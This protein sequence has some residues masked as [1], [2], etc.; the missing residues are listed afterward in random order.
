M[1][2]TVK[3]IGGS[4]AVVIPKEI[5]R[6]MHL[7]E[8]STLEISA[9]GNA[10]IL[11]KPRARARQS[12][13]SI[14]QNIRPASYKRRRRNLD[15]P[16]APA[17]GHPPTRGRRGRPAA[18]RQGGKREGNEDGASFAVFPVIAVRCHGST[19]CVLVSV[20]AAM[21]VALINFARGGDA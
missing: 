15:G 10:I 6:G 9:T 21:L 2:I 3:K 7:A 12:L 17:T 13:E 8:G 18:D 4:A 20:S 14:V 1:T 5:A 19:S 16:A 11:R